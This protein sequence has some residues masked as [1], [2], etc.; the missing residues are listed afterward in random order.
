MQKIGCRR[1]E[2]GD[3]KMNLGFENLQVWQRSV[4]LSVEIYKALEHCK[5]YGLRD[6]MHR[7]AVSIPSNISE[8][9]ERKGNKEFIQYL[10]I[11]KG[12]CAELRT[13]LY[14]AMTTGT[15]EHQKASELIEV[16]KK[17]SAM[18]YKL[19][20]TRKTKF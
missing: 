15:I 13:Q 5:D 19:I 12:S 18:L 3:S 17:I 8:G 16:T 6:Q 14:I 9:F 11:A 4:A 2:E 7:S 1:Q 10:Y 20:E